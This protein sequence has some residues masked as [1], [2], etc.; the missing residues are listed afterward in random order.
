MFSISKL[1]LT[2]NEDLNTWYLISYWNFVTITYEVRISIYYLC[3]I[4]SSEIC[5]IGLSEMLVAN[6][7]LSKIVDSRTVIC[8][9]CQ[10]GDQNC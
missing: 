8:W 9:K 6:Q 7:N 1:Y 2:F 3:N 5:V 10:I 4:L